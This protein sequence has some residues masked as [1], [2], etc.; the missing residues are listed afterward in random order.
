MRRVVLA[1]SPE[2]MAVAL[3]DGRYVADGQVFRDDG[4]VTTYLAQ[5][6]R[7]TTRKL[8]RLVVLDD[9]PPGGDPVATTEEAT[10][11]ICEERGVVVADPKMAALVMAPD[12]P[13]PLV[14]MPCGR[15]ATCVPCIRTWVLG[16]HNCP[17]R[18][19]GRL[20]CVFREACP[21]TATWTLQDVG[22]LLRPDQVER[23]RCRL[24]RK[25]RGVLRMPPCPWCQAT[26]WAN[27]VEF[28]DRPPGT[29]VVHCTC[30]ARCCFHCLEDLGTDDDQCLTCLLTDGA[31]RAGTFNRYFARP[32]ANPDE[33]T[34][35][36]NFEVTPPM[37]WAEL[38]RLTAPDATE[39]HV[40]AGCGAA[41]ARAEACN[42]MRHC[43][44]RW[45][46]VCGYRGLDNETILLDHWMPVGRCPRDDAHVPVPAYR[47]RDGICQ[48]LQ[49][50]D[51]Q[52]QE[53]AAGRAAKALYCRRA[54]ARTLLDS[55]PDALRRAVL[56]QRALP[57][58]LFPRSEGTNGVGAE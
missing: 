39:H 37:V 2:K 56:G 52:R 43:D 53:H 12:L 33:S 1:S 19:D 20:P 3:P 23:V 9:A 6:R 45:C 58:T 17:F 48:G 35:L 24:G 46:H 34:L 36:R 54:R 31:P 10:C 4:A 51:C 11:P 22:P 27:V 50:G 28:R 25:R 42:E 18:S 57:T 41:V 14:P 8:G 7:Y 55:L 29:C 26:R 5:F 32:D 38:D 49:R 16:D 30:G 47:C 44:R 21:G 40:C 13:T 15:H